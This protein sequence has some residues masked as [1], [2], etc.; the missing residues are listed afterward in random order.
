[1]TQLRI[2]PVTMDLLCHSVKSKKAYLLLQLPD[3]LLNVS[4]FDSFS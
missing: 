2:V 4:E 1:M 3:N